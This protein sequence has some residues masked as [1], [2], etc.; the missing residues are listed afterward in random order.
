MRRT[1]C[2]QLEQRP[3]T[4]T[5]TL[6]GL[7]APILSECEWQLCH[8]FARGARAAANRSNGRGQTR[9]TFLTCLRP[10]CQSVSDNRVTTSIW[11]LALPPARTTAAPS[12][13]WLIDVSTHLTSHPVYEFPHIGNDHSYVSSVQP[14]AFATRV[15]GFGTRIW[16]MFL[17]SGIVR[18]ILITTRHI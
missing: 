2:S 8:L 4:D 9:A 1:C 13:T 10:S 14:D 7:A 15:P 11:A 5:C 3:R 6:S 16:Y 18:S 12:D 17:V